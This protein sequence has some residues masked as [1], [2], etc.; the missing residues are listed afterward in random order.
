MVS[1]IEKLQDIFNDVVNELV[2]HAKERTV[3]ASIG[4]LEQKV[5]EI[6]AT[7]SATPVINPEPPSMGY[8]NALKKPPAQI[9]V[10]QGRPIKTSVNQVILI[11]PAPEN[12]EKNPKKKKQPRHV[13]VKPIKII[14]LPD[15]GIRSFLQIRNL[16]KAALDKLRLTAKVVDKGF[17]RIAITGVPEN[18]TAQKVQDEINMDLALA[19]GDPEEVRGQNMGLVRGWL[20]HRLVENETHRQR[21]KLN[22]QD[23]GSETMSE[24][25]DV[26]SARGSA[27]WQ[28]YVR[29]KRPAQ[30]VQIHIKRGIAQKKLG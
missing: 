23:A 25:S 30:T 22:G 11:H 2:Q 29:A 19:E 17:P 12:N 26:L 3:V 18:L 27:T 28:Q 10:N 5:T 8:A 15:K 13:G 6:K 21:R 4:A 7:V 14:N 24:L 20:K 16:N 9:R 1:H